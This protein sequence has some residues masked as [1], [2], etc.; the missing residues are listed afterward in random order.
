MY[1]YRSAGKAHVQ[2]F[3]LAGEVHKKVVEES[4]KPGG[5][6]GKVKESRSI[7]ISQKG[8]LTLTHCY[9]YKLSNN[10]SLF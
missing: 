4:R 9:N 10:Y 3:F 7:K 1:L 5:T 2:L 8:M 6:N